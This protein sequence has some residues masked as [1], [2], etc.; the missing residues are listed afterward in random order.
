M[1]CTYAKIEDAKVNEIKAFEER[2]GRTLLAY[3]CSD[4]GVD[5]MSDDEIREL[6]TLEDKMCIQLVAVQQ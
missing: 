1:L 2:T 3:A 4:L 6:K 5:K